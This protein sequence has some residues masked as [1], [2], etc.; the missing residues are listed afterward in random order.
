MIANLHGTFLS[1]NTPF[2]AKKNLKAK[3]SCIPGCVCVCASSSSSHFPSSA[4]ENGPSSSHFPTFSY[5]A[6]FPDKSRRQE[7][8]ENF[9]PP[10]PPPLSASRPRSLSGGRK[11]E[12]GRGAILM[13]AP[14]P[15]PPPFFRRVGVATIFPS[16][17]PMQCLP[18]RLQARKRG[19]RKEFNK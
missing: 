7:R 18:V 14:F 4:D 9:P 2:F 3:K 10:P 17:E 19:R 5:L 8:P 16:P 12:Q 1:Y 15:P 6:I 11:N 13:T